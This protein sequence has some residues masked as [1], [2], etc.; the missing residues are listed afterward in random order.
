MTQWSLIAYDI[1][2]PKRLRRVHA[3]LRQ[4]AQ[5][6]QFSVFLLETEES[7]LRTILDG[8][9]QRADT[10]H[11]DIRL[12]AVTDPSAVWSAGTQQA[13]LAGLYVPQPPAPPGVLQRLFQGLF[14]REAA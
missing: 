1:R 7:A 12:Y 3:Y 13:A 14:P 9:R 2:D 6:L 4:R 5:A 11:D 10:R 8:V